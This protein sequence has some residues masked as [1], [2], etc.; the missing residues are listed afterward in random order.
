M[1]VCRSNKEGHYPDLIRFTENKLE[2]LD[3]SRCVILCSPGTNSLP[4]HPQQ[5]TDQSGK[6]QESQGLAIY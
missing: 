5:A 1:L 2:E 3:P 6:G 4:L